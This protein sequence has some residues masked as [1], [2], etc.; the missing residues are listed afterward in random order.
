VTAGPLGDLLTP[1]EVAELLRVDAKTVTRWAKAGLLDAIRT[2]GGHRRYSAAHIQAMRGAVL[3]NHEVRLRARDL[4]VICDALSRGP[5]PDL[6]RE[7]VLKVLSEASVG[8]VIR[9]TG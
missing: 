2:P 9:V 3:M 6:A 1:G 5:D 8:S 4:M 7:Q